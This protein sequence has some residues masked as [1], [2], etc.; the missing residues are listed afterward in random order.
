M[1]RS[2][3]RCIK[4]LF[5]QIKPGKESVV[6]TDLRI[7]YILILMM[8]LVFAALYL[9]ISSII[10]GELF[11]IAISATLLAGFLFSSILLK[12]TKHKTAALNF[13]IIFICALFTYYFIRSGNNGL[14]SLWLILFPFAC[15]NLIDVRRGCYAS[16]YMGLIVILYCWTPLN[17]YLPGAL[18]P[19]VEIR[20]PVLFGVSFLIGVIAWY[21]EFR[22]QHDRLEVI[23]GLDKKVEEAK[24]ENMDLMMKAIISIS[25]I[26]DA[27]DNY[28]REHSSRVA[29]YS[30]LIA[31]ELGWPEERIND[32]YISGLIHDIGKVGIPIAIINK[33]GKLDDNE[34][35]KIKTHPEIGYKI[36]KDLV[37]DEIAEGVYCHHERI[38]GK[39]YPRGLKKIPDFGRVIAIADAFDAMNSNRVYRKSLSES[40]IIDQLINGKGTQ[41]DSEY[42][43]IFLKLIH[44]GKV[45]FNIEAISIRKVNHKK[46]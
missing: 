15:I 1:F 30:R 24:Q 26:I 44:E 42:V 2:L 43:D 3:K 29:E 21:H 33:P 4:I 8:G 28:T 34:Y 39:G 6:F 23:N 5:N 27:K 7:T 9:L 17:N 32:I 22:E 19:G 14:A 40:Y 10:D 35:S 18:I 36:V 25:N 11:M 20:L 37:N 45:S 13:F 31:I 41:F 12:F 46:A 16:F 38:D